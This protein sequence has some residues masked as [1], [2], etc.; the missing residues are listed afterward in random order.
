MDPTSEPDA[1]VDAPNEVKELAMP[2]KLLKS[3]A[4]SF[5]TAPSLSAAA[6][7]AVCDAAGAAA[8]VAAGATT[9]AAE[10]VVGTTAAAVVDVC[11]PAAQAEDQSI[12][13]SFQSRVLQS[14]S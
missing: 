10:V 6:P 13:M 7:A 4:T 8:V 2:T 5:N 14:T 1:V 11:C 3:V 12:P 9:G